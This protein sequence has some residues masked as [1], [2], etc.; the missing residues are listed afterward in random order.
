MSLVARY[1]PALCYCSVLLRAWIA[2][3]LAQWGSAAQ[4]AQHNDKL[5]ATT[6]QILELMALGQLLPPPLSSLRDVIPHLQPQEVC[7]ETIKFI[8]F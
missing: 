4:R 1:R 3:L 5:L 2:T 6:T 8:Y 7:L